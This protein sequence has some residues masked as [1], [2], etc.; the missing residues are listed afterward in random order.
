MDL[1][2]RAEI[3]ELIKQSMLK[4][5]HPLKIFGLNAT[6]G[7]AAK[8]ANHLGTKLTPHEEV[9]FKDGEAYLRSADG[10]LGNVRGHN[11]FVV[12]SL[13]TDATESVNDKLVKLLIFCGS[14]RQAG[15]HNL[16][17][18]IPHLAYARQ[19]EK[20]RSRAPVTTKI[21]ANMIESVG[22]DKVLLL[23]VHN[24]SAE[25]NA[26]SIRTT[27]DNLPCRNL[28]ADWCEANGLGKAKKIVVVSPDSGGV[29]RAAKV[30]DTLSRR[31]HRDI[32]VGVLDKVR[33]KGE[34][35]SSSGEEKGRITIPVDGAEVVAV[36]DM[37][38]TAGTMNLCC[39]TVS[40]QGGHVMAILASHGLF[41]GDANENLAWIDTKIVVA[42]SV[43]PWRLTPENRKKVDII[44]TSKLMADAIMRIHSGTGSISEL[45]E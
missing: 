1:L 8:V 23:D 35:K 37:I 9:I 28:F 4:Y 40:D 16:T 2:L 21:V 5:R 32:P 41:A 42:D 33:K 10:T 25:Q 3:E 36:D 34:V 18:V 24:L 13:Y 17:T 39:S 45:I 19:D 7:Y 26:F 6:K 14:L 15:C 43:D 12:Q 29:K 38:S 11:I 44:D 27:V 22:V 31:F 30:A 20:D